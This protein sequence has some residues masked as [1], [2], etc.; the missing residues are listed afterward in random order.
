MRLK[1]RTWLPEL[2]YGFAQGEIQGIYEKDVFVLFFHIRNKKQAA[3]RLRPGVEILCR[4]ER[5][6]KGLQ[7]RDIIVL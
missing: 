3:L 5:H 7:A 4:V 6:D 2:K 1:I